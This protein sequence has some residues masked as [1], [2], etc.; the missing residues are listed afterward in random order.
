MLSAFLISLGVGHFALAELWR[1]VHRFNLAYYSVIVGY[2]LTVIPLEEVIA[3]PTLA[4]LV[5]GLYAAFVLVAA[6][7]LCETTK[8]RDPHLPSY[9]LGAAIGVCGAVAILEVMW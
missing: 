7:Y 8:G 2:L 1:Q 9:I 4:N 5:G 6:L 3:N